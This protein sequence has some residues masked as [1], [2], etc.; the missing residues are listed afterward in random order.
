M[1]ESYAERSM[2]GRLAAHTR[3]AQTADRSAATA[4]ARRGLLDRF[5]RE[6]DPEGQLDPGER[7]R[8]AESA[9]KA[10]YTRLALAS[11]KARRRSA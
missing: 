3:W 9:K 11:A 2:R 8:R 5:E 4:P 10:F 6:V 1:T 7:Q